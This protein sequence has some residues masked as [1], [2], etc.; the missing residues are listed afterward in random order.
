[1]QKREKPWM[2]LATGR[3]ACKLSCFMDESHWLNISDRSGRTAWVRSRVGKAS[4]VVSWGVGVVVVVVELLDECVV[5]LSLTKGQ[6]CAHTCSHIFGI[7]FFLSWEESQAVRHSAADS[8]RITLGGV[9]RGLAATR[10]KNPCSGL[11]SNR[12]AGM[13]C[14]WLMMDRMLSRNCRVLGCWKPSI[15]IRASNTRKRRAKLSGYR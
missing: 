10:S 9:A 12:P 11:R 8:K 15:G 1:M 6:H 5:S 14:V 3:R 13:P 2:A 4:G 7:A